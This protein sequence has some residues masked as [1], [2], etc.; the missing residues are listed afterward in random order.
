[1]CGVVWGRTQPPKLGM[2]RRMG[3][4]H[5]DSVF[6]EHRASICR[7]SAPVSLPPSPSPAST[8]ERFFSLCTCH[9]LNGGQAESPQHVPHLRGCSQT[10]PQ[11]DMCP[12]L[13]SG[14]NSW[15]DSSLPPCCGRGFFVSVAQQSTHAHLSSHLVFVKND[16][17]SK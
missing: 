3:D 11:T 9:L 8:V 15:L 6:G 14:V 10:T 5:H 16:T 17:C 13:I 4:C 12:P 7:G 2:V 1:M